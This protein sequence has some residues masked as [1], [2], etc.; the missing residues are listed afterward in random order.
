M[1]Y[2]VDEGTNIYRS[3]CNKYQAVET[4]RDYCLIKENLIYQVKEFSSMHTSR[5]TSWSESSRK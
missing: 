3:F 4:S 2:L 5:C 1:F